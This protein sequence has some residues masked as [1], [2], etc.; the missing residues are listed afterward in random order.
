MQGGE[1]G[2]ILGKVLGGGSA[3]RAAGICDL[4]DLV[5]SGTAKEGPPCSGTSAVSSGEDSLV[6]GTASANGDSLVRGS[7]S[8]SGGSLVSGVSAQLPVAPKTQ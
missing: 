6:S 3:G 5:G 1:P 2:Q 7:A 4:Y 8:G